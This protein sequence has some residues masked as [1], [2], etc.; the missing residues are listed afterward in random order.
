MT[1]L[2]EF[3][4]ND[5][6][7]LDRLVDGE[8]SLDERRQLLAA[9]DDEPA[10]WR[11]C[12]LAFLEAQTWRLEMSRLANEPVVAQVSAPAKIP[13]AT[14]NWLRGLAVAASLLL[15]F[16]LGTW[17]PSSEPNATSVAD[18]PAVASDQRQ[19]PSGEI[20]THQPEE[21][22]GNTSWLTL[23]PVSGSDEPIHVPLVDDSVENPAEFF[24]DR[25][26]IAPSLTRGLEQDGWE[27][28][29]RQR[30]LPIQLSDGRQVVVPVEEVEL[31]SPNL[32]SF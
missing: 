9:F 20:D 11:R 4:A 19:P 14:A 15:A 21:A 13:R 22:N 6:R 30:L 7:V 10:A 18:R 32:V 2:E 29:R 26:P 8:L 24:S 1:I 16:A 25:A 27:V 23:E 3:H 17:I 12:A 5:R 28:D 31:R